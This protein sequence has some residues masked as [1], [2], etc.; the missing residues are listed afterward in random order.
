M[1]EGRV[2]ALRKAR[3]KQLAHTCSSL[4]CGPLRLP[5]P[6]TS[7]CELHIIAMTACYEYVPEGMGTHGGK[8]VAHFGDRSACEN[9]A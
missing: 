2:A 5:L 7:H 6:C 3:G 1:L 4:L 8:E 9:N